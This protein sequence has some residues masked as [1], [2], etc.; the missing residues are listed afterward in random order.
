MR[1]RGRNT[2]IYKACRC[3]RPYPY[4]YSYML[5]HGLIAGGNPMCSHYQPLK[6]AELLLK[7]FGAPNRPGGSK[8]NMCRAAGCYQFSRAG[9]EKRMIVIPVGGCLRRLAHRAGKCDTGFPGALPGRPTDGHAHGEIGVSLSPCHKAGSRRPRTA[10]CRDAY[11]S[12]PTPRIA[13]GSVQTLGRWSTCQ[14]L[15]SSIRRAAASPSRQL[16]SVRY[17][18]KWGPNCANSGLDYTARLL[19]FESEVSDAGRIW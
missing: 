10:P 1:K 2:L 4:P 14:A 15:P 9:E 16:C 17:R 18:S 8:Y 6:D 3:I 19:V 11:R 13:S 5:A 12:P 7:K